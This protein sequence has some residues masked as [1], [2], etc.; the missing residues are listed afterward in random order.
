MLSRTELQAIMDDLGSTARE[1]A[2]AQLRLDAIARGTGAPDIFCGSARDAPSLGKSHL[3]DVT[4]D[5]WSQYEAGRSIS[6]TLCAE[7]WRWHCPDRTFLQLIS[8]KE[9]P[10]ARV[11][12]W[13]AVD[14]T[15]TDRH[16]QAHALSQIKLLQN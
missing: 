7:Y 4:D 9:G 3:R 2:V 14:R 12:Y 1:R 10:E 15:T 8:G 11:D 5:E 6:E 13:E 16:V